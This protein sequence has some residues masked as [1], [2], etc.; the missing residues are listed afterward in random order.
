MSTDTYATITV[1]E[2]EGKGM[3]LLAE[4]FP[5]IEQ[6]IDFNTAP[7]SWQLIHAITVLIDAKLNEEQGVEE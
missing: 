4:F 6:E 3:E 2:P 7:K 5:E 1:R